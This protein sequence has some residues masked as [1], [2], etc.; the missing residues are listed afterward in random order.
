MVLM[1]LYIFCQLLSFILAN[2][3]IKNEATNF[4]FSH[5]KSFFRHTSSMLPVTTLFSWAFHPRI[6]IFLLLWWSTFQ[7]LIQ[8]IY[9]M[10]RFII[11]DY[12][13]LLFWCLFSLHQ[14]YSS[15]Y[16]PFLIFS[17]NPPFFLSL[18]AP[19]A[20]ESVASRF[21][22]CT[23]NHLLKVEFDSFVSRIFWCL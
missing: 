8:I 14:W 16:T 6:W 2:F 12:C 10:F 22:S 23:I 7:T 15:F 3:A 13:Y 21:N 17:F 19:V 20:L 18:Q 9:V 4:T 1:F 5:L 11:I